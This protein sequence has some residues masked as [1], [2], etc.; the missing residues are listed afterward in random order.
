MRANGKTQSPRNGAGPEKP[1]T[2]RG[3]LSNNNTT[4]K[5]I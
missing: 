3:L 4:K 1:E 2:G 5:K